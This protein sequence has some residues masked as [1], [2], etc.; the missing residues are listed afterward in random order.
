MAVQRHQSFCAD[1]RTVSS[2]YSPSVALVTTLAGD[3]S[4]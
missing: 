1:S 2:F 4:P 3:D